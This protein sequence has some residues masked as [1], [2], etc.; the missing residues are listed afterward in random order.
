M[1]L[2]KHV[3]FATSAGYFGEQKQSNTGIVFAV[4]FVIVVLLALIGV[5][6]YFAVTSSQD[7]S[8]TGG[9]VRAV[10]MYR[11]EL[12]ERTLAPKDGRLQKFNK[13]SQN[14]PHS[15]QNEEKVY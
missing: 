11:C 3:L 12:T 9:L 2:L 1:W 5:G 10:G 6:N 8:T 14:C 4:V 15:K 13:C 7:T